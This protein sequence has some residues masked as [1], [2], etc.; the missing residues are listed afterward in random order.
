M[1]QA[2]KIEKKKPCKIALAKR[3]CLVQVLVEQTWC[4]VHSMIYVTEHK[5]IIEF[6]FSNF[7]RIFSY[8]SLCRKVINNKAQVS[9]FNTGWF[10]TEP[11]EWFQNK[12][13]EKNEWFVYKWRISIMRLVMWLNPLMP[14]I[15]S[16]TNCSFA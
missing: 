15:P 5:Q 4:L 8:F 10:T 16:R 1:R 3:Q 12:T 11:G 9:M 7:F 2:C 6:L 13:R 14:E